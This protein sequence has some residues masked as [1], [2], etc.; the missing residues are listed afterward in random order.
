MPRTISLSVPGNQMPSTLLAGG[1]WANAI[2][3][4]AAQSY[5]LIKRIFTL[6]GT[7]AD[8]LKE[9]SDGEVGTD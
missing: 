3:G 5:Q 1:I 2:A 7:I 9:L 8:A 6:R 4:P